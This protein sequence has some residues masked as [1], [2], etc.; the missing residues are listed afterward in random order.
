MKTLNYLTL[1]LLACS[2]QQALA[3]DYFWQ[4]PAGLSQ[5]A[6]GGTGLIQMPTARHTKEGDFHLNYSDSQEYRFWTASLQLFPWLEST[7]RYTDVRTK[8]YSEDPSFSGD[9][10]YK[11]K[12]IDLKLRLWQ[13]SLYLPEVSVGIRDFG[14][15]GLFE[16]EFIAASKRFGPVDLHLGIGWGYLGRRDNISNPFCDLNDRFCER[17]GGV[18]GSG[19]KV[20][21][22]K[23][24]RG[25]ASL[26]AGIEYQTPWA[27]LRLKA[28]YDGNTYQQD[29][30]GA[31]AQDSD[32]NVAAVYAVNE[33]FDINLNYQRGNTFG[34]GLSYKINFHTASQIKLDPPP[35]EV[36]EQRP[37]SA[38]DQIDKAELSKQLYFNAGFVVNNYQLN[39]EQLV[40]TGRQVAFR[41]ENVSMERIGRV[42]AQHLPESVKDYRI[43]LEAGGMQM[44]ETKIDAPAFIAAAT[45]QE[46]ELAIS[47]SFTRQNP[48]SYQWVGEVEPSGFGYGS[49]LFWIQ[50]FGSPEDFYMYQAGLFA[51]AAYQF[52]SNFGIYGTAKINLLTNFDEFNYKLDDFD[53][54]LPRVRTYVREYVTR[55]DITMENLYGQWKSELAPDWFGQLYAG[56]LETM[57]GGVGGE[58]LYR[59]VDSEFAVGLDLNYVKQRSYEKELAFFDYTAFTGHVTAYWQPQDGWLKDSMVKVSAGQYLA[60]DKG[61]TLEFA[62]RFDSGIIVG[63]YGAF[64]NV[65]SEQYGEGSFTKGMYVSIPFDLFSLKS[66][67][68]R[69]LLPWVPISRDG[70]QMLNR[71]VRLMDVTEL[72]STF[73]R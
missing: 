31:L 9:Q 23:F 69:G 6:Q 60:K 57:F 2:V 40:L 29:F 24:F 64:T 5:M 37:V 26:Y 62:R 7:I 8:L 22:K 67:T 45:A 51:N 28:E 21:Y 44:V 11:D 61:V 63:A 17:P 43:V 36:T 73:N 33:A 4:S 50:S 66:A 10:T 38:L 47:D 39:D 48:G 46:P 16:S 58:V 65:S 1:S 54:D 41:D 20:E 18:S 12:G 34:F 3:A 13:E 52:N 70:G 42:L 59:P 32:F 14:G 35:V 19:G 56:Y 53:T 68:G 15:T 49:N 30:A 71:P 27:P 25:P 55:S 72:R